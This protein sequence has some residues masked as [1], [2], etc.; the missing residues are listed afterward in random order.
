[1]WLLMELL[2]RLPGKTPWRGPNLPAMPLVGGKCGYK[3]ANYGHDTRAIQGSSA[4]GPLSLRSAIRRWRPVGL[5]TS[6]K[7]DLRARRRAVLRAYL[8]AFTDAHPPAW[9]AVWCFP[10]TSIWCL[11]DQVH[12]RSMTAMRRGGPDALRKLREGKSKYAP[13][14]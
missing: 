4:T 8:V 5:R 2:K 9:S 1:M 11:D 10:R 13:S 3:L 12:A 14:T 6:G 7:T